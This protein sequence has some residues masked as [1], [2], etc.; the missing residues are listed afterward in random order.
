MQNFLKGPEQHKKHYL[1]GPRLAQVYRCYNIL[2]F[3]ENS[4]EKFEIWS[5]HQ[6]FLTNCVSTQDHSVK[7][8]EAD[9][10]NRN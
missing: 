8:Q 1:T 5:L 4:Q 3:L 6:S 9:T 10:K 2:A 7:K